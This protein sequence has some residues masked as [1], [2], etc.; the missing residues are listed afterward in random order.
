MYLIGFLGSPLPYIFLFGLYLS[1]FAFF[2]WKAAAELTDDAIA[3]DNTIVIATHG[4]AAAI[5]EDVVM[6]TE[7]YHQ[8][9][10]AE[11]SD[12]RCHYASF[13]ATSDPWRFNHVTA[14]LRTL[15]HYRVVGLSALHYLSRFTIRP[16][17]IG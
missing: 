13:A 10:H 7:A 16:P 1:G 9:V 12:K 8:Q 3:G 4:F 14:L 6:Y 15:N 11:T 2:N 17:P 5:A